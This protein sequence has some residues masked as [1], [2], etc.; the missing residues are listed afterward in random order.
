MVFCDGYLLIAGK[1]LLAL[2]S[3]NGI[4]I[5]IS[6]GRRDRDAQ[7]I[8]S[9]IPKATIPPTAEANKFTRSLLSQE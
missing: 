9:Q 7:I 4:R 6:L 1:L 2:G 3:L 5:T 8:R